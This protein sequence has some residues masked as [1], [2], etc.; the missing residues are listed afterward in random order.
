MPSM[1]AINQEMEALQQQLDSSLSV[2]DAIDQQTAELRAARGLRP[3]LP[4]IAAIINDAC[5]DSRDQD[6]AP[7]R[8]RRKQWWQFWR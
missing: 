7:R 3:S 5:I 1:A 6:P 4:D 8:G 2:L